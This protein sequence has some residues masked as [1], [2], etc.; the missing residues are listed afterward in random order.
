MKIYA[1]VIVTFSFIFS[2][3]AEDNNFNELTLEDAIKIAL[4]NNSEINGAKKSIEI[5]RSRKLQI[6]S[7]PDVELYGEWVD[8]PD[9][10]LSDENEEIKF[11]L[12]QSFDFPLK[13]ALR[14]DIAE[15]SEEI[16]SL[17][18]EKVQS[19]IIS[20]V[21]KAYYRVVSYMQIKQILE[22]I[23]EI[24]ERLAS[25]AVIKYQAGEIMYL[26]ISR[27]NIELADARNELIELE[28]E[29][30]KE[31]Y[32]LNIIL[33]IKPDSSLTLVTDMPYTPFEKDFV[34][35][36]DELLKSSKTLKISE[37]FTE[38]RRIS[39]SLSK[40]SYAP[41]FNVGLYKVKSGSVDGI[42]F[43]LTMTV[44]LYFWFRQK[45]EINEANASI[46]SL[47]IE[48]LALRRSLISSIKIAYESVNTYQFQLRKYQT[49]VLPELESSFDIAI[50]NYQNGQLSLFALLDFYRTFKSI[51]IN[52][53]NTLFN[54]QSALADLEV[55]NETRYLEE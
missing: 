54:Y 3:S 25:I 22:H 44:P 27:L 24:L 50:V 26:E 8:Y 32:N 39:K 49:V 17:K 14:K 21:K 34:F 6:I 10:P 15:A 55:S 45:G 5:T 2:V 4:S 35:V 33:G 18:L 46:D 43:E 40:L 13:I 38:T 53:L 23:I 51:K 1:V 19:L 31:K 48:N 28:K 37:I 11:G 7:I 16:A 12:Y 42:G 36:E 52:Y 20:D 47:E 30:N 29:L 9:Y 41:D